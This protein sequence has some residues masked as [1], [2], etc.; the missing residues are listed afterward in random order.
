MGVGGI[1][2]WGTLP[3]EQYRLPYRSF[4]YSYLIVPIKE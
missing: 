4:N 1:N 2:S 3:L